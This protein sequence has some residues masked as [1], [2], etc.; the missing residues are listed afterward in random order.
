MIPQ[1]TA[2]L[3]REA[4]T[5][6]GKGVT[7]TD[8]MAARFRAAMAGPLD[9][10]ATAEYR[11]AWFRALNDAEEKIKGQHFA[12]KQFAEIAFGLRLL[13]AV[14]AELKA[15]AERIEYYELE[16]IT[17]RAQADRQGGYETKE[18]EYRNPDRLAKL[19]ESYFAY[20]WEMTGISTIGYPKGGGEMTTAQATST[21][22]TVRGIETKEFL[23]NSLLDIGILVNRYLKD[24]WMLAEVETEGFD[25][26]CGILHFKRYLPPAP[27]TSPEVL[28]AWQARIDQEKK[29]QEDIRTL[30]N[31]LDE[32]TFDELEARYCDLDAVGEN[33]SHTWH[34]D[35][36]KAW[37][38]A[39]ETIA[40]AMQV[41]ADREEAV[42]K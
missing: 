17:L 8:A 28:A 22:G 38:S 20:G 12:S 30:C 27:A 7:V 35:L 15:A 39:L 6:L 16:Q 19:A 31:D 36:R 9:I 34:Y 18:A 11:N 40:A 23:F 4:E 29:L 24:G 26:H 25:N 32:L 14:K 21:P 10:R 1:Q 37:E 33:K 3:N 2:I 42:A 41:A 5:V 13:A